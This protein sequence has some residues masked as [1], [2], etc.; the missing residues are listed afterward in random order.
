MMD[1]EFDNSNNFI[2]VVMELKELAGNIF[3]NQ[4]FL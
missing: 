2:I 3:S 4:L 1:F